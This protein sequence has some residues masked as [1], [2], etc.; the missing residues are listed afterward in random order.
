MNADLKRAIQQIENVLEWLNELPIPTTGCT[1]KMIRLE[2]AIRHIKD[3]M[4]D[5]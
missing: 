3:H 5:I 4:K 1:A 2:D